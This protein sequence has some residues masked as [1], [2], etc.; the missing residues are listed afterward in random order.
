M[1]RFCGRKD[2][3]SMRIYH[4]KTHQML[5][6][7]A[8]EGFDGIDE[9]GLHGHVVYGVWH[10]LLNGYNGFSYPLPLWFAEGLAH[11]HA[12]KVPSEFLN[13][14]I[15]EDEAVAEEKQTN[16]PVKVR[17]RAQHVGAFFPFATMVEW[18]KWEDMG[19]HMHAQS[20]SRVDYLMQQ[21]AEKVGEMIRQLKSVA[22]SGDYDGQGA[23]IRV[24]AQKL[25][26][27]LWGLDPETF[28]QRWRDWVLKTYPKK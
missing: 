8:L 1:D 14:Q 23:Q 12:R 27:D 26:V 25:L 10:N 17:R 15:R 22:P 20:W 16:W 6:C 13:V 3:T 9:G 28:D 21:D 19:Y 5:L 18:A 7:V 2:D 24:M 11:W 4:D